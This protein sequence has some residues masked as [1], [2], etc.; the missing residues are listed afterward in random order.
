MASRAPIEEDAA[1]ADA[2]PFKAKYETETGH[3]D[4][5]IQEVAALFVDELHRGQRGV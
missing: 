3:M 2:C 1:G 5:F 4:E